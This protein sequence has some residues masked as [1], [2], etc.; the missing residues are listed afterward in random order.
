MRWDKAI[1]ASNFLFPK[2]SSM[3]FNYHK[4]R[5]ATETLNDLMRIQDDRINGYRQALDLFINIDNDLQEEFERF[6]ADGAYYKQQLKQ[7][8]KALNGSAQT[9]VPIIG[10]IYRAWTDLRVACSGISRKTII[11]SCQY[12]EEIALHAYKAALNTNIDMPKDVRE[13]IETQE[14][15]LRKIYDQ[16]K[17][18]REVRFT[19]D[20]QALYLI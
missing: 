6:I 5:K 8:L 10:K 1:A 16:I 4:N 15:D 18:Y 17:K 19:M 9:Q 11:A 12:N 7:K 14:A 3:L 20:Y 2:N 13:L